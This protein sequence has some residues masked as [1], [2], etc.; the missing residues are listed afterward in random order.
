MCGAENA[1][2]TVCKGESAQ[3]E[4]VCVC[5]EPCTEGNINEA[6]PVCGTENTD[7]AACKGKSE[8]IEIS[9][10]RSWR[11]V[12][13]PDGPT[14]TE[15]NG[16]YY[17]QPDPMENGI[18]LEKLAAMLP[19][20]VEAQIAPLGA[21]EVPDS[22]GQTVTIGISGWECAEYTPATEPAE[23]GSETALWPT[24]GE[25]TFT[26]VV[27]EGYAFDTAP[28]IIVRLGAS[29]AMA[30]V[31]LSSSEEYYKDLF[32][33]TEADGVITYA[34]TKLKPMNSAFRLEP[35][36]DVVI[37]L[38][39]VT[40]DTSTESENAWFWIGPKN[41]NV[42]ITVKENP[43]RIYNLKIEVWEHP[44]AVVMD[45][46]STNSILDF[47]AS[48]A[49]T[50]EY[51]GSSA[52]DQII[53]GA[54]KNAAQTIHVKNTS[55]AHLNLGWIYKVYDSAHPESKLI[56]EGDIQ[57]G[58]YLVCPNIT[59][60]NAEIAFAEDN[61]RYI[62]AK[63]TEIKDSTIQNVKSISGLS[64]S[65]DPT[66][67]ENSSISVIN[68]TVYYNDPASTVLGSAEEITI[69]NSKIYNA[70]STL[71][72]A[73]IGGVFETLTIMNNSEVYAESENSAAIG[74]SQR[75]CSNDTT[76]NPITTAS[77]II[78]NSKVE[79]ASQNGAA[80]GMPYNWL[81][82]DKNTGESSKNVSLTI[83]I[84]GDSDITATSIHS[85]AIGGGRVGMLTTS[86]DGKIELGVDAGEIGGWGGGET[87]S[88]EATIN[89]LRSSRMM[90][91]RI[92]SAEVETAIA[93]AMKLSNNVTI[94]IKDS[95]TI[96]AKSGV[97]AVYGST[98]TCNG[99]N[100]VQ[101]T[102]VKPQSGGG[103]YVLYA[104][105][106]PGAVTIGNDKLGELGYGYASVARTGLNEQAGAEM[107]LGN[108]DLTDVVTGQKT[109]AV[110]ATGWQPLFTTPTL[111]LFGTVQLVDATSEP[112]TGSTGPSTE[113][114]ASLSDLSPAS[115]QSGSKVT[116]QWYRDGEAISG[117]TLKSYRVIE[118]DTG[119]VIY[120]VVTG[121]D[122]YT[123]SVT[124]NAV[125][126]TASG[127]MAVP[128]PEMASRTEN[129]ITLTTTSG[130]QYK[131]LNGPNGNENWQES[132]EFTGLTKG[133]T[134]TFI[135]KDGNDNISP[136]ASFS[137][138]SDAPLLTDFAF[139]Y[140]KERMTFPSDVNIYDNEACKGQPINQNSGSLSVNISGYISNSGKEPQKLYA[141]YTTGTAVTEIPVPCRPPMTPMLR[142]DVIVTSNSI[143]F[144][145]AAGVSYQLEQ[146]AAV[147]K[148][149]V[150]G[151]G[152]AITFDGLDAGETYTLKMRVEASNALPDPHFHS[153]Q[154]DLEIAIPNVSTMTGT[155]LVPA[156]AAGERSYD[157]S[158][159]LDSTA[160]TN[161]E[162]AVDTDGI[163][164]SNTHKGTTLTL[165][166]VSVTEDKTA[167]LTVTAG[168]K[169][170]TL[171]VKTVN[172]MAES[173][174]VLWVRP[175][176][177]SPSY[178]D[179]GKTTAEL[180]GAL[181]KAASEAGYET[182]GKESFVLRPLNAVGGD[183]AENP[184]EAA[185][186]F[187]PKA[188]QLDRKV[189]ALYMIPKTGGEP[190][191]LSTERNAAGGVDF[192]ISGQG[193][194]LSFYYKEGL[195][196]SISIDNIIVNDGTNEAKEAVYQDRISVK[197]KVENGSEGVPLTGTVALYNGK[198]G[199]ESASVLATSDLK[200]GVATLIFSVGEDH[201]KAGSVDL[202]AVYTG[203]NNYVPASTT[204]G[205][206]LTIS[207]ADAS[208]TAPQ[209]EQNLTYTGEEQELVV[210]GTTDDGTMKYAVSADGDTA[211][212]A[213][214]FSDAIPTGKDAGTYY[215]WYFVEGDGNHNNTEATYV[216]VT[217]GKADASL[218]LPVAKELTYTGE[219]QELVIA[220][221]T[222][223]GTMK[224]AMSADG[225][226]A[227]D[228]GSYD[229]SIPI[230]KDAGTYY[231]WYFVEGDGNHNNTEAAYVIV[232]IGKADASVTLPVAKEL[233]YTGEEQ[234]LVIA[235]T[236]NDG[237]VKYAVSADGDTAP[238]AEQFS[239]AIPTGTNAGIYYV[240]Y[241]VEG[242][243]NHNNTEP[244][245]VIVT[246]GKADASLTLPVAKELIYTGEE[247]ELVAAGSTS[248]GTMK[249]AMS[250]DG[251][252]APE[253]EQFS[254]AIPT[255]KDAGTYYVWYFVEGDD[256]HNNTE[257]VCEQVAIYQS[258]TGFEG[259]VTVDKP[260]KTYTYGST[261]QIMVTP[262][263]TG[264][265]AVNT[266]AL[267]EPAA[268]QIAI[269]EGDIQLTEPKDVFN[270][271]K[272]TFEIDTDAAGLNVG[273][274]TLTARFK[275]NGN[276]AAGENSVVITIT[277]APLNSAQVLVD[278]TYTYDGDAKTPQVTVKLDGKTL[279]ADTD[280]TLSYSNSYGGAGDLTNAGTVTVTAVGRGNYSGTAS[281]TF[282]IGKAQSPS[283]T[284][285][286]ASG[287]TYGQSLLESTLTGGS[288]GYG[289]FVWANPGTVPG[290]GTAAYAVT[291]TP[292]GATQNNYEAIQTTE[293]AV[294][295]TVEKATPTIE[296]A[297]A[298][299]GNSG[300]REANLTITVIGVQD[301]ENP[302]GSV[303]L[304][305]D[306]GLNES[307]SL[308][309]GKATYTW[310]SLADR[311]YTVNAVYSGDDNYAEAKK[312]NET[313]NVSN[314]NYYIISATA[315]EGGSIS[316]SGNISVREGLDKTFAITP[317]NGYIIS[318]V[319][320]DGVS[321]GAVASYTFKDVR[322]EHSIEVVFVGETT[323]TGDGGWTQQIPNPQ[324][325]D[326][327]HL[328]LWFSIGLA[329]LTGIVMIGTLYTVRKR[330]YKKE[331]FGSSHR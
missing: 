136:A 3:G 132:P 49:S 225:E 111:V 45:N 92:G 63:T 288:T 130:Y 30:A 190:Q 175:F 26:A 229:T 153:D 308:I 83:T 14:V 311:S 28:E 230:G 248:D 228:D 275:A 69:N 324:T 244:A 264:T 88:G 84:S 331:K 303:T 286:T 110:N 166:T 237:T 212:E 221:T 182:Q 259:G 194:Y 181:D 99:T 89:S 283:I 282:V 215:V 278:G 256:N 196:A 274:H 299:S 270:G 226:T 8:E 162:E 86:D 325:G 118:E 116:Y 70:S 227:P 240:W 307:L 68:S 53:F 265:A 48:G 117:K 269:Y 195:S 56:L 5:T 76:Y 24:M 95:P 280:Y 242:D 277:A 272:L 261:I 6:C 73:C 55:D 149:A 180:V 262:K 43:G 155:I 50:V 127:G 78:E 82:Y 144:S 205:K 121:T 143:S 213:E 301:G 79:A 267:T 97:L 35:E 22:G 100:L 12:E 189:I 156:N 125:T 60:Q 164:Y 234:E 289:D 300:A 239:D 146:N 198:P 39:G 67:F 101:N 304:S 297:V 165:T 279:S 328:W 131:I 10:I 172:V 220:G 42:T 40:E 214:Q 74:L 4:E 126:V 91:P 173:D 52:V 247:Q 245:Y 44:V 13:N 142:S 257:P 202:Y 223:D 18:P 65:S 204:E 108:S 208:L 75:A 32:T 321:V 36:G 241:F 271:Q 129:S 174:G 85:A 306:D 113:L 183:L 209:A 150:V 263:A 147:I 103:S 64:S 46:F 188:E 186:S 233:T 222:N 298:M 281:G 291:F 260:D 249:Y 71:D 29:N 293:K 94:I 114:K 252:T 66:V 319:R 273:E 231:V 329:S 290:G 309:N 201:V 21:P 135:Q 243:G 104:A 51:S 122:S 98:V 207:K 169:T 219:E 20:A 138:L 251:E 47:R 2:L 90:A 16:G 216:T 159:W 93:D 160:I 312:E 17:V 115:A 224:Y 302:S 62:T 217:I 139:D 191:V 107:K 140:V 253:A 232:T 105:E 9:A 38:T 254:D 15:E 179:G 255:G 80:I 34:F 109:V 320:V 322:E 128:A 106:N 133:R 258:A 206:S 323:G 161:V 124:S 157:L 102:M 72:N 134:Y 285:P 313:F 197:I 176:Y 25:Y 187:T 148:S 31:F 287:L 177:P 87:I 314:Y 57:V 295:V 11:F 218:T 294:S 178:I 327:S 120:C 315:G 305:G 317:N 54:G 61:D 168:N 77:I 266:L 145:G 235:G 33:K 310:T 151:D 171:T 316:P 326:S 296:I 284:W 59:I 292:S 112:V 170:L 154:Y 1:D 7:L 211:P 210:A 58:N 200:E 199:T 193:G 330:R 137:T 236:T 318:D 23:D 268:G 185:V 27:E 37:D 119:H 152:G 81:Y 141:K 238:E 192:T 123:G 158:R 203:D 276:M 96:N 163:V 167:T 246:I 41:E 250:A 19:Q 184:S